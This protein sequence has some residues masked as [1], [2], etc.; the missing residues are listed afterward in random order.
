MTRSRLLAQVL[1]TPGA[2]A[3]FT[4]A[5]GEPLECE[6]SPTGVLEV[7][8]VSP[9]PSTTLTHNGYCWVRVPRERREAQ[10]KVER[11]GRGRR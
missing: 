5:S 10:W 6:V 7:N 1:A 8:T 11:R 4:D 9:S 2:L 3:S